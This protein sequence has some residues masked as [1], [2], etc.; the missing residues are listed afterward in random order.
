MTIPPNHLLTLEEFV[1]A[2]SNE[3]LE[4]RRYQD[5]L[6]H[7]RQLTISRW[8]VIILE[9]LGEATKELNNY[10]NNQNKKRARHTYF[11]LARQELIQAAACIYALLEALETIN[12]KKE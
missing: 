5:S 11:P 2:I 10:L 12:W 3:I 4:E 6:Y 9:E 1:T 8:L 7:G